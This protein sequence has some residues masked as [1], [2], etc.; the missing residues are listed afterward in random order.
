MPSLRA[1]LRHTFMNSSVSHAASPL[2]P[3]SQTARSCGGDVTVHGPPG[4]TLH[5]PARPAVESSIFPQYPKYS[6]KMSSATKDPTAKQ[7]EGNAHGLTTQQK[8]RWP[9]IT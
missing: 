1:A 4:Q 3:L 5:I 6:R 2:R 9:L 8:V 7:A